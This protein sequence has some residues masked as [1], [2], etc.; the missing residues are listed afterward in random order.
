MRF[1]NAVK[2][3]INRLR[4][5]GKTEK[6]ISSIIETASEKAS[7][8]FEDKK[9]KLLK[10][11]IKPFGECLKEALTAAGVTAKDAE[12]AF[13]GFENNRRIELPKDTNNWRRMHGL[14]M[15]RKRRIKTD[16]KRKR[17]DSHP[18]DTDV[19]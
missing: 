18:K 10:E 15:R 19:S 9:E 11:E 7:M 17:A 13:N 16:G 4:A 1:T 12:R 14:P 6:E 3:I 2:G 5:A 8:K